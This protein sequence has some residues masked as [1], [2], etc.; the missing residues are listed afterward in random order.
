M[1]SMRRD[2]AVLSVRGGKSLTAEIA[3]DTETDKE[4]KRENDRISMTEKKRGYRRGSRSCF[5]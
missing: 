5:F 2:Q 4:I 1:V 3:E